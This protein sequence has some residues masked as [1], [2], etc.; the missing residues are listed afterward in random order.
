MIIYSSIVSEEICFTYEFLPDAEVSK[1]S[2][3]VEIQIKNLDQTLDSG[4]YLS[5]YHRMHMDKF[6]WQSHG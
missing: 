3:L 6:Q 1:V 2:G 5:S 4:F